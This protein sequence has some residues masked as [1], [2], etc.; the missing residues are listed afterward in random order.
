MNTLFHKAKDCYAT[1]GTIRPLLKNI[2]ELY[3]LYDLQ[4]DV[5]GKHGDFFK[6]ARKEITEFI[7]EFRQQ[8]RFQSRV[9]IIDDLICAPHILRNG[10]LSKLKFHDLSRGLATGGIRE[11]PLKWTGLI[12]KNAL[13]NAM[14]NIKDAKNSNTMSRLSYATFLKAAP[15][16]GVRNSTEH[17]YNS[18]YA[19]AV[20]L[21]YKLYFDDSRAELEDMCNVFRQVHITTAKENQALSHNGQNAE[22]RMGWKK[23]YAANNIDLV[24]AGARPIWVDSIKDVVPEGLIE[25]TMDLRVGWKD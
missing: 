22:D 5:K 6:V 21:C 4:F 3:E 13:S 12:S 9:D 23:A 24:D 14:P 15:G 1:H 8:A 10:N 25:M 20:I 18:Q 2:S 7:P 16:H 17:F 11:L 19:A